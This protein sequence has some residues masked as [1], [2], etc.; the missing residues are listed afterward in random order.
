MYF[1]T[2]FSG[3]KSNL[4]GSGAW[5]LQSLVAPYSSFFDVSQRRLSMLFKTPQDN[6]INPCSYPEWGETE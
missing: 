5:K 3:T 4:G 2:G 6:S 1:T